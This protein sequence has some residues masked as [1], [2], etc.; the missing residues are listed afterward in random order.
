MHTLYTLMAVVV[1]TDLPDMLLFC[2]YW[3]EIEDLDKVKDALGFFSDWNNLGLKLDLHPDLL[4]GIS[5]SYQDV[6]DR[7]DQVLRNWL[8]KKTMHKKKPTW[9]AL[10]A[11][12]ESINY[13]LSEKIKKKHPN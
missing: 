11:A 2:A 12:L 3:I 1:M 9:S 13:A 8:N 10:V 5:K 4:E 7:L 6:Y